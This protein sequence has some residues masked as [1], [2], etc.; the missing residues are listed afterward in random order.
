ME[1]FLSV[2]GN[3]RNYIDGKNVKEEEG[4]QLT[5]SLLQALPKSSST[6]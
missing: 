6:T 2:T 4:K 3:E 1:L 5:F